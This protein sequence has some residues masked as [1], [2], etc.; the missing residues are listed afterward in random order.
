MKVGELFYALGIEIDEDGKTQLQQLG[1][2]TD[3]L[4][5]K[6]GFLTGAV[7]AAVY[8]V[9]RFIQSTT[10]GTI[11]L[12][13][14]TAQTGESAAELQKWQAAATLT[15]V[16]L[17]AEAVASSLQSV[18]DNLAQIRISG[19]DISPFLKAG[20][21]PTSGSVFE[22]LR[23]LRE[24]LKGLDRPIATNLIKGIGLDPRFISLLQMTNEEFE[25]LT[26]NLVLTGQETNRLTKLNDALA[27]LRLQVSLSVQKFVSQAAPYII[28]FFK[29]LGD[30]IKT[31]MIIAGIFTGL[32]TTMG[33]LALAIKAVTG[34]LAILQLVASPIGLIIAG[35]MAAVAALILIMQ[36]I[37]VW[38]KGG[39]SAFG[40]VYNAFAKL[41]KMFYD[42]MIKPLGEVVDRVERLIEKLPSIPEALDPKSDTLL[43]RITRK[44][45][46]GL[47]ATGIISQEQ[48]NKVN[49]PRSS[50]NQLTVNNNA[51]VNVNSNNADPDAV[52]KSA[53]N[54]INRAFNNMNNRTTQK[55]GFSTNEDINID[56]LLGQWGRVI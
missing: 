22:V 43:N 33:L 16:G 48:Y 3:A 10:Q 56:D 49:P 52:G 42:T 55:L 29:F 50:G 46:K 8:G 1:Q 34:A 20:I 25:Q 26:Q 15:N 18:I 37:Y 30:H 6:M 23:D 21:S 39:D 32:V 13:N 47:L 51:N 44:I 31:V 2:G 7:A 27:V 28:S 12:K 40:G 5:K 24:N 38:S 41:G 45:D 17:S 36:D 54:E 4:A 53:A 9:D 14:F 19:G 35:I 11:T